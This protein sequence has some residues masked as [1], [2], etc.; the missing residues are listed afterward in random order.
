MS[1]S[2]PFVSEQKLS[3]KLVSGAFLGNFKT[4][5]KKITLRKCL[6]KLHLYI[7][8]WL[9][10][11][12]VI[13]GLTGSLLVY[14][15]TLDKWLNADMM[16]VAVGERWLPIADLV[17]IAN[18]VS[19]I[20]EPPSH[21]QMPE[22][23]SEA[24]IVRYQAAAM[25]GHKGH[26]HHFHE[27]M[28][29]PYSGQV[30]GDRDRN[31]ALMTFI[32]RLHFSLLAGDFGKLVMGITS[33]LTL[34]L[35]VTGIYL[36]WPKLGK[37]KQAL[38]IKRNASA[39]RFNFDLHKTTGIY[40]AIVMLAVAFS[41]VYFNLPQFFKPAVNFF[42]PLEEMPRGIKSTANGGTVIQPEIVK[43]N[44]QATY[45]GIQIQRIFL[46]VGERGSYMISARQSDELRSKGSTSFWVDQ[47]DG[48][49]LAVRDPKKF[50]AGNAFINL[51]LPLHNGE[52][53]GTP[54][55]IAVLVAGFAPLVM[56]VTGLI[57]WLKKRKANRARRASLKAA[58]I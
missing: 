14:E 6:L 24:L 34:V 1:T 56:M 20:P 10:T 36:W 51:Q 23:P 41:G 18:R 47:Y 3:D 28:V 37:I 33:L 11:L 12:I 57:H 53:L 54:G 42:S 30:L 19:P 43:A 38:L 21:L 55:R 32:L 4:A 17:A 13:A 15:H 39:T 25:P 48:A 49:I 2:Y 44:I 7:S 40:T 45:P 27:V 50:N 16:S 52:I 26:N 22:D 58:A 9:G 8:L 5:F 31:D 35:T 29:N 46:P